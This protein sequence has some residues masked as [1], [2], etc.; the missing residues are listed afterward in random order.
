M[1][2]KQSISFIQLN[3]LKHNLITEFDGTSTIAKSTAFCSNA[4]WEGSLAYIN[5][6]FTPDHATRCQCTVTIPPTVNVEVKL[7]YL[8]QTDG[9][10]AKFVDMVDQD[11]QTKDFCTS[12]ELQCKD[13]G[14]QLHFEYIPNGQ[15]MVFISISGQYRNI[16]SIH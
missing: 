9:T 4:S 10:C 2:L 13:G 12:G 14:R 16:V 7:V 1:K 5:N 8:S 6:I 15:S 3:Q 11:G